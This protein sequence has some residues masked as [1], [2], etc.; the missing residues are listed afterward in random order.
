MLSFFKDDLEI[1][2]ENTVILINDEPYSQL[3]VVLNRISSGSEYGVG[4]AK[5]VL[6]SPY[7]FEEDCQSVTVN[8]ILWCCRTSLLH[9][10]INQA[11]LW[12]QQE[13]QLSVWLGFWWNI[14]E[15]V[16]RM[17]NLYL[18]TLPGHPIHLIFMC[19]TSS[20]GVI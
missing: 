4:I 5:I 2:T 1:M 11:E 18:D 20:C 17:F 16:S 19:V 7:F 8:G 12:F 3:W 9:N 6:I 10:F 14:K 15:N 13:G